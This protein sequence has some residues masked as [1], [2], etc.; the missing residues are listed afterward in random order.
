MHL[1]VANLAS[2][3]ERLA[4]LRWAESWD[5]VGLQLGQ[6]D[7]ELTAV[8][9][10]MD[11]TPDVLDCA[12][13]T[14]A[15]LIVAHH[16]LI[17]TPLEE[18]RTDTP[19]GRLVADLLRA[20]V[21]FYAAHTNLDC[22]PRVGPAAALAERLDLREAR[23]LLP[24]PGEAQMKLVTFLPVEHVPAVR[25]ALAEAGAGIIGSY[26]ECAFHV[27]GKGQF[28]APSGADPAVG[29]AD[30]DNSVPEARLEMAL[31]ARAE[32]AVLR[33][34]A[35][36]HPY[37]EPA[38]DLYNLSAPLS[39]AGLGRVG[40]LPEAADAKELARRV[41]VTLGVPAVHL[42]GGGRVETLAVLPGSGSHAVSPALSAGAQAL[43]TGELDYHA[44]A[45]AVATG[46]TVIAAGHAES[47]A[48]LLPALAQA[49]QDEYGDALRIT[50]VP[51]APTWQSLAPDV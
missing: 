37:E 5:R 43:L 3:L 42:A 30:A 9:L 6:P 8:V 41:A 15:G 23:P 31:P 27:T 39:D 22:A 11:V 51:P 12:C 13:R 47:E 1:T 17:F 36:A 19:R 33:A 16:P 24:V 40:R 50:T 26:R 44:T 21:S 29:Q 28:R 32:A 34:L 46:L 35:A 10:A 18:V 7:Q 2:Y 20:E 25:Q 14:G 38:F 45:E 48:P 4:P 49:L